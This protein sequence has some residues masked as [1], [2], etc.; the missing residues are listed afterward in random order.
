VDVEARVGERQL[1]RFALHEL[2]VRR[3][4]TGKASTALA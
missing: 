3:P 4:I 2:D 1:L